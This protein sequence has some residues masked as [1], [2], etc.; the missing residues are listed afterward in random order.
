MCAVL[1]IG[2]LCKGNTKSWCQ[3]QQHCIYL[4][5]L[6]MFFPLLLVLVDD[7]VTQLGCCYRN[8][9][10]M[11]AH[12]FILLNSFVWVA[13]QQQQENGAEI[14]KISDD[15]QHKKKR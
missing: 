15:V 6:S 3:V 12:G 13:Q 2:A 5:R 8:Q 14:M 9:L 4:E 1:S 10:I 7:D 11:R